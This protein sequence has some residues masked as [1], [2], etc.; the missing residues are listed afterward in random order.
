MGWS[1]AAG[2]GLGALTVL[3][4]LFGALGNLGSCNITLPQGPTS[5]VRDGLGIAASADG[6]RVLTVD[7][8]SG[9][10]DIIEHGQLTKQVLVGGQTTDV[11]LAP[12]GSTALV[13]DS[14][15][16]N[17]SGVLAVVDLA[18]ASLT[19]R[20]SVGSGPTGVAVSPDGRYAYVADTGYVNQC[21]IDVVDLERDQ[22]VDT[23]TVGKQPAGL[24]LS[25]DGRY[26]YVVEAYLYLPLPPPSITTQPGDVAI[27]DT[28]T[29][30]LS[31]TVPVGVAPLIA[32][33]SP[34]GQTLAVGNYGSNTVTLI[35]T[36]TLQTKTFAVP[37]GAFGLTFSSDGQRLF[38]CGG[39]SSLVDGAVGAEQLDHRTTNDVSVL[40]L[41]SGKV[42]TTLNV[43]DDPTAAA[44][45][46][47]G[48]V[49]VALGNFPAVAA[50]APRS[51]AV[52]RIGVPGLEPPP[53]RRG[54]PKR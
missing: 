31:A 54:T 3:V 51:L 45:G 39:N 44:T 1:C 15:V 7:S 13:T 35:D 41:A 26:L 25:P 23:V 17:S 43:G 18:T 12:D 34:E 38:V 46:P 29:M 33:L 24:V 27:I 37:D 42:E 21:N 22:V 19:A 47:G 10:L 32:A 4:L 8:S 16:G 49:Y 30:T 6:G 52:H 28:R 2:G 14:E 40:D 9:F 5:P 48:T 50:I 36:A 11:V 53:P 20:I